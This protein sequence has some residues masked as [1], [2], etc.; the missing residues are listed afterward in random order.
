MSPVDTFDVVIVG[1]GPTGALLCAY[2]ARQNGKHV[3]LER[4]PEITSDHRGIA[5][6]EDGI[7]LL[8][9]IGI[10]DKIFTEIGQGRLERTG[11][12]GDWHALG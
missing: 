7:R 2:L 6:D 11:R 9:G 8:Q 12:A 4:E 10:Y 1:G 5:L 3:I